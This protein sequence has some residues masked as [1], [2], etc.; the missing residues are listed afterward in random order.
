[1]RDVGCRRESEVVEN[2]AWGLHLQHVKVQTPG[3]QCTY[4]IGRLRSQ[5]MHK[6]WLLRLQAKGLSL[7][8]QQ[9]LTS[10]CVLAAIRDKRKTELCLVDVASKQAALSL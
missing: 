7:G 10:T 2:G 3:P 6:A 9:R 1:M 4:A 8:T 5:T